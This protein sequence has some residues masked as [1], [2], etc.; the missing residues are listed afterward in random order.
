MIT[1]YIDGAALDARDDGAPWTGQGADGYG[2]RIRTSY[3]VAC[4]DGRTRRVYVCQHGASGA[5]YVN[6]KGQRVGLAT[7]YAPV[8]PSAHGA[9]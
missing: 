7:S 3:T 2:S 8:R 5:Y 6:V 1:F 9:A 4:P